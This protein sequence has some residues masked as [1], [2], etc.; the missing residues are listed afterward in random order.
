MSEEERFNKL[1]DAIERVA[2]ASTVGIRGLQEGLHTLTQAQ[3][4]TQYQMGLIAAEII[5]LGQRVD[6]VVTQQ[7]AMQ[8]QQAA[9]QERQAE[10]DQR[11]DVLLGEIRHIIQR[12]DDNSAA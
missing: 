12:L 4:G 10:Q 9:M 7:A 11:F 1:A 2:D 5:R 6:Q 8:A 3:L